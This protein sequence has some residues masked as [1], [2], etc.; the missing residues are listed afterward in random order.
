MSEADMPKLYT[1]ICSV[2]KLEELADAILDGK[3]KEQMKLLAT[4][5]LLIIDGLVCASCR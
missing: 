4:V 2:I 3:R 5:P 1:I